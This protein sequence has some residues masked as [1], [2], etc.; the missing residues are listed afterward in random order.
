MSAGA[1][2]EINFNRAGEIMMKKFLLGAVGA[3]ALG[4]ASPVLAADMAVRAA[5]PPMIAPM[6]YDWTGFYIGANGGWGEVHNCVD[7]FNAAGVGFAQ[8]CRD[9][10]GGLIGGQLGYR[11]QANQFVFRFGTP[12]DLGGFPH[13][14]VH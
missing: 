11:W 10:S 3:A 12:G 9:R 14:R 6:I 1:Y 2:P 5:P 7:F 8:G 4:M 13:H